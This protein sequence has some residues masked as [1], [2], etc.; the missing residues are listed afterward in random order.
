MSLNSSHGTT[1]FATSAMKGLACPTSR[2]RKRERRAAPRSKRTWREEAEEGRRAV[3]VMRKSGKILCEWKPN[4]KSALNL[5]FVSQQCPPHGDRGQLRLPGQALHQEADPCGLP[6]QVAQGGG[7]AQEADLH[8]SHSHLHQQE[9][10]LRSLSR[11]RMGRRMGRSQPEAEAAACQMASL[12][13]GEQGPRPP[14]RTSHRT[15][16][17]DRAVPSKEYRFTANYH[18]MR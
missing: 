8:H 4:V 17:T 2:R 5:T 9:G 14:G 16:A 12:A 10:V 15:T 18:H 1:A 13:I 6:R 3:V 7:G 11:R